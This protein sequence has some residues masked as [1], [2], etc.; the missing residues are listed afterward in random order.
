MKLYRDESGN[1]RGTQAEAKRDLEVW[2]TT[3]VPTS[4]AELLE[5]LNKHKVCATKEEPTE[6][7]VR[8]SPIDDINLKAAFDSAGLVRESLKR[9][10][11]KLEGE[12][13]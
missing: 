6:P 10:F 12:T 11:Y 2:R 7:K 1:W 8:I 9:V 4:K 5:F 13:K 3:D